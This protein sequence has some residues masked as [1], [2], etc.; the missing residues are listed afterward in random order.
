MV[1][2]FAG[3]AIIMIVSIPIAVAL[4]HSRDERQ[5]HKQM[6]TEGAEKGQL[7]FVVE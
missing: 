3:I 4:L 2:I 7:D 5:R 1:F 6:E